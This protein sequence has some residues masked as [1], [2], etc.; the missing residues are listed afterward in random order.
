MAAAAAKLRQAKILR[1]T[2]YDR[3]EELLTVAQNA[4]EDQALHSVFK[5]RICKRKHHSL[6]HFDSNYST[7]VVASVPA[8]AVS[9]TEGTTNAQCLPST[10]ASDV[11]ALTSVVSSGTTVLLSTASV[12][13]LDSRGNFHVIRVLLDS[14]SQANFITQT[15][16]RKLGL[17]RFRLHTPIRGVCQMSSEATSGVTCK[18]KPTGSSTHSF[19][20]D[21]VILPQICSN[22]PS[23]NLSAPQWKHIANLK[24]ADNKFNISS[25]IDM[26]L[27]ADIFSKILQEGR[28]VG[29][30]NEPTA[31]DTLFGWVLLG[32]VSCQHSSINSFFTSFDLSDLDNN[33]RRFWEIEDIPQKQF[34]SPDD[35]QCEQIYTETICRNKSGRYVVSLPF[36]N[37]VP[38]FEDTRCLALQRFYSL[39]RRLAGNPSLYRDYSNFMQDYLDN[40]HMEIIRNDETTSNI[41]QMY[42]QILVTPSHRD[43]QRIVWRFSATDPIQD[44][45]LNT[46]TFGVSSSPFL[47]LRTLLQLAKDEGHNFPL[48]SKVLAHALYVDDVIASF[49]SLDE[50]KETQSELISLLSRGV[51]SATN[52][53]IWCNDAGRHNIQDSRTLLQDA[54]GK[55]LFSAERR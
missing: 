2:A 42:R 11:S 33:I 55:Q 29:D 30:V 25:P 17:T 7:P 53:F 22:L 35:I 41:K 1:E 39:E 15:C 6:L 5:C 26:L 50:A 18:I 47:A 43:Y 9:E 28:I 10:S 19:T 24:L 45:R 36:R 44:Y 13:I 12:E 3:C 48:A 16:F 46:V 8:L 14:G 34:V 38:E 23:S 54:S 20:L 37:P 40:G 4:K 21:A 51:S 31:I 27:G 49:S 32:K 52:I